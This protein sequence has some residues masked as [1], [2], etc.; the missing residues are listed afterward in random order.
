[1]GRVK[2][3]LIDE[4]SRDLLGQELQEAIDHLLNIRLHHGDDALLDVLNAALKRERRH[5]CE[6]NQGTVHE[7]GVCLDRR[8]T[9]SARGTS[10]HQRGQLPEPVREL[11]ECSDEFGKAVGWLLI[12]RDQYGDVAF[13]RAVQIASGPRGRVVWSATR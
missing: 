11:V 2:D 9:D 4:Q 12:L 13:K 1:M 7:D 8:H 6:C 5:C 3:M 10:P